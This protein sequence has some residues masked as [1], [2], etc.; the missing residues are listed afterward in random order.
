MQTDDEILLNEF[1]KTLRINVDKDVIDMDSSFPHKFGLFVQ[2]I[3]NIFPDTKRSIPPNRWS[4]HR[5]VF[6]TKGSAEFITGMYNFKVKKNTLLIIPS[7]VITSSK[8]WTLDA[9]GYYALFNMDFFLQ[10]NFPYKNIENKNIL[11]GSYQPEVNLTNEQA[12]NISNL[13]ERILKEKASGN[14]IKNELI[15]LKLAELVIV[16]EQ[17]FNKHLHFEKNTQAMDIIKRF[18]DLVENNFREQRSVKFYAD[19]LNMHPNYLN[20]LVK[21]DTGKTAKESIQNRLLVEKQ[22]LLHTTNLSIKE[23]SG[24]MGFKD[25]NY[26]TSF[27]TRLEKVSPGNYRSSFVWKSKMI[28]CL[29]KNSLL[30]VQELCVFN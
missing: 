17:Y 2:R 3:E 9:E 10:N 12:E 5:I 29:P 14:I 19:Q 8:N 16:S 23:I 27:F 1:W 24:N 25:P 18:S 11:S 15:A 6:V 20:S 26:F 21:K 22:Y 30:E 7:R 28:I 13:F 4:Y